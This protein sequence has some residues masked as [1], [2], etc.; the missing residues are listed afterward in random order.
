MAGGCSS[1]ADDCFIVVVVVV[2][3]V[4]VN[5]GRVHTS[6]CSGVS[7]DEPPLAPRLDAMKERPVCQRGGDVPLKVDALTNENSPGIRPKYPANV[8]TLSGIATWRAPN[9]LSKLRRYR[10][11]TSLHL[12]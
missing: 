8:T 5:G 6:K 3:I 1:G 4:N 10:M 11:Q 2:V 9:R 7:I 12:H